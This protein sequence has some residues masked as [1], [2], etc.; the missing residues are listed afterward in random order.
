MAARTLPEHGERRCYL[1]G[2]RRPECLQ[3]HYRYMSRYRLDRERG[4]TR[5]T[6]SGPAA[7]HILAL[8]EAG[9]T[10]GQIAVAA[11]CAERT[12][13]NLREQRYKTIKKDLA[14]RILKSRPTLATVP[15]TTKISAVGTVR[16]VQALMAIGHSLLSIAD[17]MGMARTALSNT[18][19]GRRP[20]VEVGTARSAQRIYKEWAER[21]GSSVRSINRAT[22]RGW[23]P[24]AAWDDESIDDPTAAPDW[25]GHCGTDRGWWMHTSQKLPMCERCRDAHEAWK[26]EH[27]VLPR[28]KYMSALF[29]AR[30]TASARGAE[31]AHDGRELMRLGC[32]AEQAAAR[33][34]IT[35]DYLK[36]ELIRHPAAE[37]VAA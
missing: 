15:G 21:P 22:E 16:R 35:R 30:A 5:R 37:Q 17:A 25:T 10:I 14:D 20:A 6:P 19:C 13:S 3:A 29:L 31:I 32:T 36:Q 12:V 33:L 1:R 26:A 8:C 2:C 27:R 18:L 4:G 23:A 24:P 9:W 28:E 11:G 7:R 34:G